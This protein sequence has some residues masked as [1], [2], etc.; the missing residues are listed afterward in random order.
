MHRCT[1]SDKKAEKII[2]KK[3]FDLVEELLSE[4]K[5]NIQRT[6]SKMSLKLNQRNFVDFIN[7]FFL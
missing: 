2:F 3:I 5:F 7:Q 6:L 1:I 4:Y